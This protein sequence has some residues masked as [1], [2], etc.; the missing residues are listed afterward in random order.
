MEQVPLTV[1]VAWILGVKM[2]L[3]FNLLETSSLALSIIVT[4][5]TLQVIYIV[6]LFDLLFLSHLIVRTIGM[7]RRKFIHLN[8]AI[9]IKYRMEL[10]TTWK[11]LFF[12]CATLSSGHAFL[13]PEPQL[14]SSLLLHSQLFLFEFLFWSR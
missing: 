10:L 6:Y 11:A 9:Y 14:V 1:I 5:F 2:D 7:A 4:A 3:N 8:S 12:Y 13:F